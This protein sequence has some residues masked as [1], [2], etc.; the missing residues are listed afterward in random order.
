M[1]EYKFRGKST[2]SKRWVYGSLV[3][4]TERSIPEENGVWIVDLIGTQLSVIPESVG[5]FTGLTDK[6]GKEIYKGDIV[7]C[8]DHPTNAESG[9]FEVAFHT[10]TFVCKESMIVLRDFGTAWT[11]VIGNIYENPELMEVKE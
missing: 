8:I 10:G 6:N 7:K 2:N 1:K 5:Q 9:V 11:E 3:V 4:I